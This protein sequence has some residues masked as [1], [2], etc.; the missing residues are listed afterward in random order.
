MGLGIVGGSGWRTEVSGKRMEYMVCVASIYS[1]KEM[2]FYE[3]GVN[4]HICGIFPSAFKS[5]QPHIR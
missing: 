2:K 5:Q 4:I 3:F 1:V